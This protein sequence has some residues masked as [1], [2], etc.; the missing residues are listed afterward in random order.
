M[1]E[2]TKKLTLGA[3]QIHI[4]IITF[5]RDDVETNPNYNSDVNATTQVPSDM[6]EN[7]YRRQSSK[8]SRSRQGVIGPSTFS[9]QQQTSE[10]SDKNCLS[11]QE[12]FADKYA[13]KFKDV[14]LN[15][16][17]KNFIDVRSRTN[18]SS[19]DELKI[20][21]VIVISGSNMPKNDHTSQSDPLVKISLKSEK[22]FIGTSVTTDYGPN[23]L[24]L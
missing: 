5:F 9:D 2:L 7:L 1:Q 14:D 15:I 12:K 21:K 4:F 13:N 23:H 16:V 24:L 6:D 3:P 17:L 20:L 18:M 10:N 22:E 19:K 8:K 11:S